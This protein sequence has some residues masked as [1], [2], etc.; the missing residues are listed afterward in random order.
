MKPRLFPSGGVG[1][2]VNSWAIDSSPVLPDEKIHRFHLAR[3]GSGL[4]LDKLLAWL[5][6]GS[7]E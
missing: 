1:I 7:G 2:V 4:V 3:Y 6:Q 5:A